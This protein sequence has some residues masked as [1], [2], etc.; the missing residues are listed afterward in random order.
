MPLFL[1]EME[2][3][4]AIEGIET[5]DAIEGI[6]EME[7]K[8]FYRKRI[9][10]MSQTPTWSLRRLT[11]SERIMDNSALRAALLIFTFKV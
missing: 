1:R 2:G 7:G 6:V 9:S 8:V 3:I 4:D 5:I 10:E 11:Y